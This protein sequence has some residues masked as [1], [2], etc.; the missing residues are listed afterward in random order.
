MSAPRLQHVG[1]VVNDM[2]ECL[3]F[4]RDLLGLRVLDAGVAEGEDVQTLLASP[5]LRLAYAELDLGRGQVLELLEVLDGADRDD[6]GTSLGVAASGSRPRDAGLWPGVAHFAIE[7]DD[8]DDVASRLASAGYPLRSDPVV[9]Q[10][11]GRWHGVKAVYSQDPNGTL[12]EICQL[13]D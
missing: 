5:G 10:E 4:Y 6:L 2:E 8:I 9:L 3:G 11:E 7:V 12:V 1:I 13:P